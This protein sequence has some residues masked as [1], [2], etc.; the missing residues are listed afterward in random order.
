MFVK[1]RHK[2]DLIASFLSRAVSGQSL[3]VVD[4]LMGV[5]GESD[6]GSCGGEMCELGEDGLFVRE[7]GA[8]MDGKGVGLWIGGVTVGLEVCEVELVTHTLSTCLDVKERQGTLKTLDLFASFFSQTK[9]VEGVSVEV[10][11]V[12]GVGVGLFGM[13]VRLGV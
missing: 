5:V 12:S 9:S 10:S 8:T 6:M 2:G 1:G 4:L 7:M 13:R 11:G 3:C